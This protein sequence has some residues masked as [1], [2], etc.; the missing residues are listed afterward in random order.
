MQQLPVRDDLNHHTE[1]LH[2]HYNNS[3]YK[4]ID[5]YISRTKRSRQNKNHRTYKV[6]LQDLCVQFKQRQMSKS[7]KRKRTLK[8]RTVKSEPA[9]PSTC[10]VIVVTPDPPKPDDDQTSRSPTSYEMGITSLFEQ[11]ALSTEEEIEDITA[12]VEKYESSVV[13]CRLGS[14]SVHPK[15]LE[16]QFGDAYMEG[17]CKPRKFS[18]NLAMLK[19]VK[20]RNNT[21]AH[22]IIEVGNRNLPWSL[23]V[24]EAQDE[25]MA[26]TEHAR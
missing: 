14:T 15:L 23:M 3:R 24:S 11:V 16:C 12:I 25:W 13:H 21:E 10:K 19:T 26:K 22:L 4:R 20:F 7:G 17:L 8:T 6:S 9:Q 5:D 1:G 2:I 18:I